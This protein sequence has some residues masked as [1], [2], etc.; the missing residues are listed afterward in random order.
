MMPNITKKFKDVDTLL[1]Q[2][3]CHD[4]HYLEVSSWWE[5]REL[6]FAFIDRPNTLWDA[7]RWWWKQRKTYHSEIILD[8]KDIKEL[9]NTLNK[10]LDNKPS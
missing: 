10:F 1:F 2:C 9:I 6:I 4:T 5:D 8:R 3:N 7:I